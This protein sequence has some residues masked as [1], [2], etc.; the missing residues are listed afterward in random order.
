[1][2]FKMKHKAHIIKKTELDQKQIK[3]ENKRMPKG[4][5]KQNKKIISGI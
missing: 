3:Q 4:N 2:A 1:M 5:H